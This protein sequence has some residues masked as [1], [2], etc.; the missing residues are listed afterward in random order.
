MITSKKNNNGNL[1]SHENLFSQVKK[2]K[3]LFQ[4][5]I[6]HLLH[7]NTKLIIE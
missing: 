1:T 5:V 4:Y 3:V 7:A 2:K 6:I